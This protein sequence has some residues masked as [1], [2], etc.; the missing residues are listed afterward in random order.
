MHFTIDD[1]QQFPRQ[2]T[3]GFVLIMTHQAGIVVRH[4]EI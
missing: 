4:A 2:P 1:Q 3:T